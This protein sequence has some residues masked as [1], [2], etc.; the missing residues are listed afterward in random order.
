M[1]LKFIRARPDRRPRLRPR[2]LRSPEAI[3][4]FALVHQSSPRIDGG[5]GRQFWCDTA[6]RRTYKALAQAA[7]RPGMTCVSENHRTIEEQ[8]ASFDSVPFIAFL[9]V[10]ILEISREGLRLKAVLPPQALG[11]ALYGAFHGGAVATLID[12]ACTGLIAAMT[13]RD[14]IVTVD[15]RT[16]FHRPALGD[17][18]E[19]KA[20]IVNQGRTFV[21][22]QAEVSHPAGKLVAS[23]RLLATY[24]PPRAR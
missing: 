3:G 22:S 14:D 7:A 13:R 9:G 20:C 4:G 11:N 18:F 1:R 5:S 21:V 24:T 23:G 15:L 8:Q 10:K 16:D 6:S 2:A 12:V 19:V 17:T